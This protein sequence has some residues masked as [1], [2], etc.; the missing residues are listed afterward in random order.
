MTDNASPPQ[1][2]NRW[3]SILGFQFSR[4]QVKRAA[5]LL[6]VGVLAGYVA[7]MAWYIPPRATSRLIRS[8]N[9]WVFS[10][11]PEQI[12][13]VAVARFFH[14]QARMIG[15]TPTDEEAQGVELVSSKVTD[16]WMHHLKPLEGLKLLHIHERQLGP[17][18]ADLSELPELS[19]IVVFNLRT[20]DLSHL[21]RL[22][23]LTGVSLVQADCSGVD[24]S[25]LTALPKL[26]FL[27]FPSTTLTAQQFEQISQIKTLHELG[28]SSATIN[29]ADLKGFAPLAKMPTLQFL[30]L[31]EAT[32]TAAEEI[33]RIE[34][35]THLTITNCML[36]DKGATSL[37]KLRKLKDLHLHG[38]DNPLDVESLRKLMP[39][40]RINYRYLPHRTR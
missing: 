25:Q 12:S 35:L 4:R 20:S 13:N 7:F 28:L 18:L 40:C 11:G 29:S 10:Y 15:L 32:D 24:L 22:P 17:G 5:L 21:Q 3:Y 33:A 9:G 36:T 30:S 2:G 26:S 19:N 39:G 16:K 37:A 6:A 27:E 14:Q 38:C 1:S 23:N 31:N 34:S 8:V